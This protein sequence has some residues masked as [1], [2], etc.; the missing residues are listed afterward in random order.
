MEVLNAA[1]YCASA[2]AIVA[3]PVLIV[4]WAK[5][6]KAARKLG[7]AHA[8]AGFPSKSI[9]FFA[10]PI[11]TAFTVASVMTSCARDDVLNF[12]RGASPGY[13]VYING[14]PA[15]E[16]EKIMSI[17]KGISSARPHHSHPT[18]RIRVDLKGHQRSVQLEVAR[19]SSNPQEYW[20]F[21]PQIA[22]TSNNEIGRITTSVFDGY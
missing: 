18:T 13:T 9:G 8:L 15:A 14:Q 22:V 20:V 21:Y 1:F 12:L 4:N 16:P 3:L 19:D 10:V 11:L 7:R 2:A 6:M 5:Y 17:L